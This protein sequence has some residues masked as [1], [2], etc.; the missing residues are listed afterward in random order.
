MFFFFFFF[1]LGVG[2]GKV[3]LDDMK[4][5]VTA[6]ISKLAVPVQVNNVIF[7]FSSP[8]PPPSP[9]PV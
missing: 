7:S 8:C 3:T 9:P 6:I 1:N 2:R 5:K 4:K